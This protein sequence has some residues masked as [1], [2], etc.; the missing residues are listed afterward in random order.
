MLKNEESLTLFK[1]TLGLNPSNFED[2][3]Q[4]QY[5]KAINLRKAPTHHLVLGDLEV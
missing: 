2:L 3:V 5:L 4:G 1:R